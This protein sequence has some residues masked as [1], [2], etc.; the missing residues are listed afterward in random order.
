MAGRWKRW[1]RASSSVSQ[2]AHAPGR[3]RPVAAYEGRPLRRRVGSIGRAGPRPVLGRPRGR[4][5]AGRAGAGRGGSGEGARRV[6][7]RAGAARGSVAGRARPGG[8]RRGHGRSLRRVPEPGDQD[9]HGGNDDVDRHQEDD[10]RRSI[11]VDEGSREPDEDAKTDE[12]IDT[13][14]GGRGPLTMVLGATHPFGGAMPQR[15]H[16]VGDGWL[17]SG[18]VAA[19]EGR[20]APVGAGP[21]SVRIGRPARRSRLDLAPRRRR[22]WARARWYAPRKEGPSAHDDPDLAQPDHDPGRARAGAR[23]MRS[24][25]S[26]GPSRRAA[27]GRRPLRREGPAKLTGEAKYA[28]DLVFPGA[29]YGATIR[30]TDAH[31]RFDGFDLDP[32]V[33]W[34]KVAVVTAADIPGENIVSLISDDQPVLVPV[35]GE[36]QHHAEPL[37]LL[38]AAG[39]RDAPPRPARGSGSG[40][41]PLPPVFDPRRERPRLRPLRHRVGRPRGR[42][43]R[44]R[45]DPRGRVPGRPPGAALHREQRDDRRP[46]RGRRRRGPR[47]APVPVLHPQGAEA[48]APPDRRA[49]A[50]RPGGDGRRVRREGGVPLDH[51][52]PRGAPRPEDRQAGPDDLRPPRGP[53]RDDE[54][55]PGGRHATGPGSRPT[56]RSSPRRSRS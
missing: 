50:G 10:E 54:A 56:G 25:S 30:S 32:A 11:H 2:R 12:P 15:A 37:V 45:P 1:T 43:R 41:T 6:G 13:H 8:A 40:P 39:S 23:P 52:P 9:G 27:P 34:S 20:S 46:A 26:A 47:L 24:S 21:R 35:G 44:G 55:A 4:R 51:R 16:R 28:D 17:E 5:V 22:S 33:D 31:A 14:R 38:A 36:I 49:G 48:G 19:R 3:S 7:A 29:W 18:A 42:L 53:R